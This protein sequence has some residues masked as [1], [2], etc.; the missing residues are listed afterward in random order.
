MEKPSSRHEQ[1]GRVGAEA[2]VGG[3]PEADDA[4]DADQEIQAEGGE[5]EA[6]HLDRDLDEV[7]IADSGSA[8]SDDDAARRP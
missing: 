1:P 5:R 4:A 2:E 6:Q 8:S 3:M 7:G